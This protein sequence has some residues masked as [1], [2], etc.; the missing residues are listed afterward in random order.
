[1]AR[2]LHELN[3][4]YANLWDL[5]TELDDDDL[6]TLEDGLKSIEGEL[7]EKCRNGIA[8]IRSLDTLIEGTSA[9]CDRLEKN[10]KALENR[11]ARIKEWY[12]KNLSEMG[13]KSVSTPLGKMT[14]CAAGGKRGIEY[15]DKDAVLKTQYT[16]T[17]PAQI[18]IDSDALRKALLSGVEVEG[19]KLKPQGRYLKIT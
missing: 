10:K 11:R 17:I 4:A 12:R 7:E 2:A 18:E 9:E 5:V 15:T 8:L 16:R 6:E 1:M 14:D 19:A 3:A 13:I